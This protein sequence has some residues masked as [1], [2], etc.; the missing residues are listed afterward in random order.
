L[1]INVL[2]PISHRSVKIKDISSPPISYE[3]HQRT[4]GV[5][6]RLI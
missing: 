1:N 4:M 2:E 6:Q 3:P 5:Y